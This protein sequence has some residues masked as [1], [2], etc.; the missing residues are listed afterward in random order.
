MAQIVER[1]GKNGKVSYLIRVSNGYGTD[2]K[3]RKKSMTW[4]PTAGMTP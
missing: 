4:T 2:G 3:Q 1:K